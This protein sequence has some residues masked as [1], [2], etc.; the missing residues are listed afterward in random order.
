VKGR[1]VWRSTGVKTRRKAEEVARTLFP[2][3][4]E[5][6]R[7]WS[8][9]RFSEIYLPYAE[10]N[11][12]P[13]TVLMYK[14]TL[15][16]FRRLIGDRSLKSYTVQDIEQY[17]V[18]RL[19]EVS[20]TKV[21]MDFRFLKAFFQNAVKW[22]YI[23]RNPCAGVK[24]LKIPPRRPIFFTKVEFQMVLD[25]IPERW[26]R[27]IILFAV[28]TMMR[29]GEI[30]NLTWDCVDLSRRFIMVE[31]TDH[32]RLKNHQP[33][34]VP[35][36]DCVYSMLSSRQV[37]TGYVFTL[38]CGRRPLASSVSHKFKVA[39]KKAGLGDQYH[40]HILRHY[41][42]LG[43]NATREP[44]GWYSRMSRSRS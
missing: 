33:H 22:G 38:P 12:A 43:I 1:R 17:K 6:P 5:P 25:R 14:G 11:L 31:N 9:T 16:D 18:R 15:N 28:S 2:E 36:N 30:V 35:M 4:L 32:H 24:A 29:V 10:A 26:F 40:F 34:A 20:A 44:P 23:E 42:E 3:L 37:K 41:A 39:I 13:S 21:N 7:R 19:A 27:E 8:L